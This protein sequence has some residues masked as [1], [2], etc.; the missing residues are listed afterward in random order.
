MVKLL[1]SELE[2]IGSIP[3]L[4]AMISEIRYE[5]T[6]IVNPQNYQPTLIM[7]VYVHDDYYGW[8]YF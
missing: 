7:K 1:A 6:Y 3:S 5:A 4:A 8:L 2:V